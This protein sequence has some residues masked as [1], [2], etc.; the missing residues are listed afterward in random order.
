MPDYKLFCLNNFRSSWNLSLVIFDFRLA[1]KE[2]TLAA[3]S[4][5]FGTLN[6]AVLRGRFSAIDHLFPTRDPLTYSSWGGAAIPID[7]GRAA[8]NISVR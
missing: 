6:G 5:N 3:L 1:Y 4:Y 2:L 7:S 8:V